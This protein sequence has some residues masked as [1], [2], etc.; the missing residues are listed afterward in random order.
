[1]CIMEYI[2]EE[3]EELV[4]I[5]SIY[6]IKLELEREIRRV[7]KDRLKDYERCMSIVSEGCRGVGRREEYVD[8]GE[9]KERV[10][11]G[12]ENI[13]WELKM[14]VN[15]KKEGLKKREWKEILEC[16]LRMMGKNSNKRERELRNYMNG[17]KEEYKI[18]KERF[19]KLRI[20]F[21]D[22]KMNSVH[23]VH[24]V[25]FI[26]WSIYDIIYYNYSTLYH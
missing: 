26:V 21:L 4:E 12:Y 11:R 5:E 7:R 18:R 13:D 20:I 23:Y 22:H 1:M 3:L 9:L 8:V 24:W 6:E 2:E 15:D 17:I 25:R 19:I 10:R 14:E 16:V